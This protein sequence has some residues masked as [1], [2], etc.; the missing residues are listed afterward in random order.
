MN[1]LGFD[2]KWALFFII[3]TSVCFVTVPSQSPQFTMQWPAEKIVPWNETVVIDCTFTGWPLP[4]ATWFKNAIPI[5]NL[6][7]ISILSNNSLFIN[8]IQ[9]SDSG[10]YVCVIKNSLGI[11]NSSPMNISV[12]CEW[13]FFNLDVMV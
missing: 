11:R 10:N 9:I 5:L 2:K 12:S 6:P 13:I 3:L 7:R 8:T 4:V 1:C